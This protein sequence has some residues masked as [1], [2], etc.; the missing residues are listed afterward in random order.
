[1]FAA[2]ICMLHAYR[3]VVKGEKG[4]N[5][6]YKYGFDFLSWQNNKVTEGTLGTLIPCD[7][8]NKADCEISHIWRHKTPC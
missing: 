3:W 2:F 6:H 5:D 4:K 8:W 7:R 1:M